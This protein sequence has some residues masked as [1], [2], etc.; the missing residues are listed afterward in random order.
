MCSAAGGGSG[1]SRV[2]SG[3]AKTQ[4]CESKHTI[5]IKWIVVFVCYLC[6]SGGKKE[7][8]PRLSFAPIVIAPPRAQLV[9]GQE[10]ITFFVPERH[11]SISFL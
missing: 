6:W 10:M 8:R 2:G 4:S 11:H 9:V 1:K 5:M 7:L 3:K